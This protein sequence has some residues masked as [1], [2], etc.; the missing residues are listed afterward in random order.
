LLWVWWLDIREKEIIII[1]DVL[2]IIDGVSR[3]WLMGNTT[4]YRVYMESNGNR[5]LLPIITITIKALIMLE[6]LPMQVISISSFR[7]RETFKS[8][9]RLR[10]KIK[11]SAF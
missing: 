5:A 6:S 10:C 9:F 11:N 2:G 8:L 7:S 1:D 4:R 3:N